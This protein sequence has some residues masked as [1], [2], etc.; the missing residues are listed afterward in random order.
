M[1]RQYVQETSCY[2]EGFRKGAASTGPITGVTFM[3]K[4]VTAA[5]RKSKFI[6]F[7]MYL[8]ASHEFLAPINYYDG[9]LSAGKLIGLFKQDEIHLLYIYEGYSHRRV[10]SGLES[11]GGEMRPVGLEE[12]WFDE[13]DFSAASIFK[14][15][16]H[17]VLDRFDFWPQFFIPLWRSNVGK[18]SLNLA[19]ILFTVSIHKAKIL[20]SMPRKKERLREV[21]QLIQNVDFSIVCCHSNVAD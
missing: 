10:N 13:G 7:D 15:C 3:G 19:A 20:L 9:T 4:P 17:M 8:K 2:A 16:P 6:F 1:S 21:T 11:A 18:V 14:I 12:E 5:Q